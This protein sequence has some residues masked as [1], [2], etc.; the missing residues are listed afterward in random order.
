MKVYKLTNHRYKTLY[1]M[2][3]TEIGN[4]QEMWFA[5]TLIVW[6]WSRDL[7]V[8]VFGQLHTMTLFFW[9]HNQP[10]FHVRTYCY[11]FMHGGPLGTT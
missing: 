5:Y 10:I 3:P 11:N 9:Q 7:D 4:V 1:S 8:E 6:L 2:R